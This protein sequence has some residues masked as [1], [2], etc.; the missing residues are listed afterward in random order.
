[1]TLAELAAELELKESY[2]RSHWALIVE[3]YRGYNVT[4]VKSGRGKRAQYGIK[5][6]GDKELRW[7]P[8]DFKFSKGE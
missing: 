2:L 6:Y 4:L 3:R 1:M 5:A 7:E 8:R